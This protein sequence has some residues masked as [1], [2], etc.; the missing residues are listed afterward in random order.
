M[1][2]KSRIAAYVVFVAFHV[3]ALQNLEEEKEPNYVDYC[4]K[5]QSCQCFLRVMDASPFPHFLWD[6]LAFELF[7]S[8]T[9]NLT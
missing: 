7:F 5:Y 9:C 8:M 2:Y 6:I 4:G 1:G 3:D